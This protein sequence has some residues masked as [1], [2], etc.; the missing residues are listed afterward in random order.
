MSIKKLVIILSI[1]ACMLGVSGCT[2]DTNK[3]NAAEANNN[4]SFTNENLE[5]DLKS[6]IREGSNKGSSYIESDLILDAEDRFK[7]PEIAE[8]YICNNSI[9]LKISAEGKTF[10]Y[11]FQLN[12][13]NKVESYIKYRVED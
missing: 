4:V 2:K 9:Y 11:R 1:S 12:S 5:T 7:E 8:K 10:L 13:N 6:L 3:N